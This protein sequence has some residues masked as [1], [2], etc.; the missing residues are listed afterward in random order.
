MKSARIAWAVRRLMI[1]AIAALLAVAAQAQQPLRLG[2]QGQAPR[3]ETVEEAL[4]AADAALA[5]SPVTFGT[6]YVTLSGED[7]INF[8]TGE[9]NH[10]G[11]GALR[12]PVSGSNFITAQVPLPPGVTVTEIE[13]YAVDNNAASGTF[14]V[15]RSTPGTNT[16]TFLASNTTAG[17]STAVATYP[18][19][20]TPYVVDTTTRLIVGINTGVADGTIAIAGARVGYTGSPGT[21]V[22]LPTPDR[23]VDTRDGRGGK[24]GAFT[25]GES[26]DFTITG[27]AGRDGRVIPAGAQAVL[28]TVTAVSPTAGG[29]FKVLPGGTSPT[30]GTSTVNFNAGFNTASAYQVRLDSSG[31]VRGWFSS[32]TPSAQAHLTVDVVGYYQ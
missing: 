11:S 6:S 21:L 24:T 14:Y 18:V 12:W 17:A 23:F 3:A 28:G 4:A 27:I 31:R 32:A 8:Y 7:F 1:L 13:F 26:F 30:V 9:Y 22:F 20:I 15:Y 10:S 19:T 5:A 25:V 16:F 29:L 2:E